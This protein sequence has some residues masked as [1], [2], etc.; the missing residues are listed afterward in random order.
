M[1]HPGCYS[2]YVKLHFMSLYTHA[3][4][5]H[6]H[7]IDELRSI[8]WMMKKAV[9]VYAD[10]ETMHKLE[11]N[12]PYI[13]ASSKPNV[14]HKPSIV[15]HIIDQAFQIENLN[16]IPFETSLVG[17]CRKPKNKLISY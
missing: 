2:L 3:H 8:N 7:G 12:F 6:C 13:F 10:K 1:V 14:F 15:P 16:I 17:Y 9:D 5:D 4:A 11:Q